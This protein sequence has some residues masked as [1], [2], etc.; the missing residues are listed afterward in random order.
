MYPNE[1]RLRNLTYASHIFCDIEIEY[2]ILNDDGKT[3]T[4]KTAEKFVLVKYRDA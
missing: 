4:V 1:A 3:T 2:N